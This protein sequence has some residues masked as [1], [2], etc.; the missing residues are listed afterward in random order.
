MP[1]TFAYTAPPPATVMDEY[2]LD[3]DEEFVTADSDDVVLDLEFENAIDEA[4]VEVAHPA[5]LESPGTEVE[6]Q[7]SVEEPAAASVS[8][9]IASELV[10][11]HSVSA[12]EVP[13]DAIDAIARRVV[14]QMSEKVVREIAWEVVPELSELLIK[15]KLNDQR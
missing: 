2:L 7:A 12:V 3:V 5:E 15:Q 14:E 1:E 9:V 8:D 6:W 4:P 13:A 10:A 11:P